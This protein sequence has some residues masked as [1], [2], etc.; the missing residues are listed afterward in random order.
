MS[1]KKLRIKLDWKQFNKGLILTYNVTP[2]QISHCA[3]LAN[4]IRY[5]ITERRL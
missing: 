2:L 1:E 4:N 3:G 5:K